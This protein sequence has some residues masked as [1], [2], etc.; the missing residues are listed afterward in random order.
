MFI[1][2]ANPVFCVVAVMMSKRY[3]KGGFNK[4]FYAIL[5]F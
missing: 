3:L 1:P 4:S 2:F 5:G